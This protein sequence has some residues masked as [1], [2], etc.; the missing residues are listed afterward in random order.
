[1][2]K[3]AT[4]TPLNVGALSRSITMC[5][6]CLFCFKVAFAPYCLN[7]TTKEVYEMSI[8]GEEEKKDTSESSEEE[9]KK[10]TEEYVECKTE[11]S[12]LHIVLDPTYY[13][14]IVFFK[15][16]INKRVTPPPRSYSLA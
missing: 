11:F 10:G 2:K 4:Y 7:D 13:S 1:M 15:D 5:L 3:K 9:S 16:A 12:N 8:E 14:R 6:L